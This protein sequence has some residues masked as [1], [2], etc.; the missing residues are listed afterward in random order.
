MLGISSLTF[1]TDY[2]TLDEFSS[3][4]PLTAGPNADLLRV[5]PDPFFWP[6]QAG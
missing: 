2:K 1:T 6:P 5:E 4:P 3:P